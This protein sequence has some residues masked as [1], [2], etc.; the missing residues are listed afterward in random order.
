M[1]S[2]RFADAVL[3]LHLAYVGFVLQGF[4][5]VP[6]GAA[7]GWRWVRQ[8]AFR[9]LH[10]AAIAAVALEAVVGLIC[11]LTSLEARLRGMAA[12]R[13]LVARLAQA[14]LFHDLPG[15]VFTAGY[16][17]LTALALAL[18]WRVPPLPRVPPSPP[19]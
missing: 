12:P 7:L 3:L 16:L 15:W 13:G 18:Y 4:V 17:A 11:P 14:L 10:L 2:E 19:R 9:R 8:R 1:A 6:L 5:T